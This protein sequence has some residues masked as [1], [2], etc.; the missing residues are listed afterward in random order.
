[1]GI[2][3]QFD[4]KSNATISK[5]KIPDYARNYRNEYL[6]IRGIDKYFECF[7]D[8]IDKAAKGVFLNHRVDTIK[9]CI[10]KYE[11]AIELGYLND[12]SDKYIEKEDIK[13]IYKIKSEIFGLLEYLSYRFD[14]SDSDSDSDRDDG[15]ENVYPGF[16]EFNK[17]YELLLTKFK[18]LGDD[19]NRRK[20]Y[21]DSYSDSDD[22]VII[23]PDS[24]SDSD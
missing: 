2:L 8:N 20:R 3:E 14:I 12:I 17:Y 18:I 5:S 11:H 16:L 15:R 22:F 21:F 7:S 1:M 24:D 9:R 4:P 10:R 13:N 6:F 23:W 19:D